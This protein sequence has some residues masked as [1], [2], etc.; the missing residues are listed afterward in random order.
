MTQ[1]THDVSFGEHDVTK[2]YTSWARQE[3]ERE[4]RCLELLAA[5]APGLA[6]EPL[7]H[8]VEAGRPYVRMS[9]LPG[10][11]LGT[12]PLTSAQLGAVASALRDLDAVPADG[13]PERIHGPSTFGGLVHE[14]LLDSPADGASD[15]ALVGR[16]RDAALSW[17]IAGPVAVLNPARA[18]LGRADGNIGNLLWDGDRCR[19][20]DLEDSGASDPAYELADLLEHATVRLPRL[21]D[22]DELIA[23]VDL[24]SSLVPRLHDCRVLMACFWLMMLLPG[25]PGARRNPP[26]SLEDQAG[27]LLALL[28]S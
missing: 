22:P 5:H 18:T 12:A 24:D 25:N 1:T 21:L 6:P 14:W 27:H 11:P 17:L 26:G 20:V 2:S 28:E 3:P 7:E 16:A 19:V 10:K 4:W 15:P 8:G 13:L 9:R 23:L